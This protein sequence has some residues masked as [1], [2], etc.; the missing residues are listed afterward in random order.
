MNVCVYIY[1]YTR[2]FL[3]KKSSEVSYKILLL[4]DS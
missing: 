3:F 1:I 4:S 2:P